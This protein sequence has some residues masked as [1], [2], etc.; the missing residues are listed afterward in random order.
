MADLAALGRSLAGVERSGEA[1]AIVALAR[2]LDAALDAPLSARVSAAKEIREGLAALRARAPEAPAADALDE[3][4]KRRS[5]RFPKRGGHT[6]EGSARPTA[7]PPRPI[8][9]G[10]A[11]PR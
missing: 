4:A 3:L 7:P 11:R 9:A 10:A 5:E 6:P 1:M 8:N 2:E